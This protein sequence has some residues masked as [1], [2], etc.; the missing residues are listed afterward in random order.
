MSKHKV[1]SKHHYVAKAILRNF[2]VSGK[3]LY[4]VS[5]QSDSKVPE[6]RNIDSVFRRMHFNSFERK[7]GSKDDTIERFFAYELD[8]YIPDWVGTFQRALD[9]GKLTFSTQD[10]RYRF[11]QFFYNHKKRSPDFTDPLVQE[12]ANET[13][14]ADLAR[15]FEAT[16][17]PLTDDEKLLLDDESFRARAIRNSRVSNFGQQSVKILSRLEKMKI[18]V[19]TPKRANKQFIVSSNPVA[20]FEDYP[21]QELGELGV[22]EWTTFAPNIAVGFVADSSAPD[23][24]LFD[25]ANV[26]NLNRALTKNS[27]AIASTSQL[28]LQ[29]LATSEW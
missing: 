6:R 8:N 9:T 17:R 29:S 1:P 20:R 26:R 13:F 5:K 11:I 14:T 25:D 27:Q 23:C 28:L 3:S 10:L 16:Y 15:E 22:E 19:G 7:D 2:C 18:I 4:Y 12:V 24:V 21:K